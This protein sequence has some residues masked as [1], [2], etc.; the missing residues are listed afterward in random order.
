MLDT[1]NSRLNIA[2]EKNSEFK[3]IA[4]ELSKCNTEK[5]NFKK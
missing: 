4:T 1:N 2:K 3:D 5:K